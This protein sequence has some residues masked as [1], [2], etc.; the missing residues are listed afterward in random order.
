[1]S[2][3]DSKHSPRRHVGGPALRA[4]LAAMLLAPALAGCGY[5]PLYGSGFA[6]EQAGVAEKMR[7]VDI[8]LVPGRVGQVVRNELIFKET[9][10]RDPAPPR[11]RLEIALR[12]S[13]QSLLVNLQGQAAGQVYALDADFKLIDIATQKVLLASKANGRAAYQQEVSTFANVRARRDAEDRGA[14]VV[15]DSIRTQVAAFLSQAG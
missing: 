3:S 8:G 5:Q 11:Y 2:S 7:A 13:A 6:G 1:M 15:S 12:E 9:G 14:R 10:G 4:A